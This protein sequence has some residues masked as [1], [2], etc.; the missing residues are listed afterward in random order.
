MSIQ[1]LSRLRRV[2]L[3][4][5][6]QDIFEHKTVRALARVVRET[7]RPKNLEPV[8][9]TTAEGVR[10]AAV[11]GQ[12]P[13]N[14]DHSAG[15]R[16]QG[17]QRT[18]ETGTG[19]L[20]PLRATGGEPPLFC[21]H[22]AAGLAWGY[23][24]LTSPLGAD[25]PVY[26]LQARGL[27]GTEALPASLREMAADYLDHVRS[28]QPEGPYHLLGWSFGG[29][30]AHEMAV[31]LEERGEA[32]ET[33]AILDAHPAGVD[34]DGERG[35]DA[36]AVDPEASAEA[37]PGSVAGRD[38]LGLLLEFFG[39]DPSLWAGASLTYP[40]VV[41]ITRAQGGPLGSFDEQRIAAMARVV[42]NNARV[43][44]LHRP[45]PFGGPTVMFTSREHSPETALGL[46]R[47]LLTGPLEVLPAD[48]THMEM[49]HSAAL[50]GVG[51][52]LVE[53]WASKAAQKGSVTTP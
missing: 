35:G 45:R 1:V 6:P 24:G 18:S 31:Q 8:D 14:D 5:T 46:W 11:P 30:V 3:L 50:G 7:T 16:W 34:A 38:V 15:S 29:V 4:L 32:V 19:V 33:L 17:V 28:V 48:C 37:A 23:A 12:R 39:Y 43:T 41:E 9:R 27:D 10:G 20:L 53:R 52:V 13:T 25:R 47:P 26:G 44:G 22:A 51:R 40:R 2:G 49:G 42:T 36:G 21:V